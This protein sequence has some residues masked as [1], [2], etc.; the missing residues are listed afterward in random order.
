MGCALN[1]PA[2]HT[3]TAYSRPPP[4]Q[5]FNHHYEDMYFFPWERKRSKAF[6]RA[7]QQGCME[8]N[9]TRTVLAVLSEDHPD[10]WGGTHGFVAGC[11]ASV[12]AGETWLLPGAIAIAFFSVTS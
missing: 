3:K 2:T 7:S 1:R 5:V 6:M 12:G 9:S 11:V 10:R 4:R 8:P